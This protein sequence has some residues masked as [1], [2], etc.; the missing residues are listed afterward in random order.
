MEPI[1]LWLDDVRPMPEHYTH[2]A[3]TYQ[4]A[5]DLLL[6]GKVVEISLDHDLGDY[7]KTGYD[8]AKWIEEQAHAGLLEKIRCKVHS[9]NPVGKENIKAALRNAY[10]AWGR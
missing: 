7:Q 10:H 1:Y 2:W 3:K 6:T 9:M 5:I 4:E 8:V